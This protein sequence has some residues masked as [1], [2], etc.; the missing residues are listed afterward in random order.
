MTVMIA[1]IAAVSENGVIGR[2]GKLPWHIPADLKHFKKITMG[3]PIIMGR[4]TFE[5]I[6]KPLPGRTNIIVS[7]TLPDAAPDLESAIARAKEIAERDGVDEIMIIGG[8][9]IFR[10]ALPVTERVYLTII[11]DDIEGDAFFPDLDDR[12]WREVSKDHLVGDPSLSF[13][14]LERKEPA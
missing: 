12:D 10:Q 6:G 14:T 1:A 11:E 5:S 2:E 7:R 3:K 8:G 4:K 13:V 9:E